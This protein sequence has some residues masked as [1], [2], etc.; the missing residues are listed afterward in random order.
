[1]AKNGIRNRHRREAPSQI[2]VDPATQRRQIEERAYAKFCERGET[3]GR[4]V[5]DWLTAEQEVL[6]GTHATDA[7]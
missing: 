7:R 3:P 5:E 2:N 4:D 1:M 6:A